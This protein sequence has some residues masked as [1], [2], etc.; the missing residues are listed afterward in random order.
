MSTYVLCT[1]HCIILKKKDKN[2]NIIKHIFYFYIQVMIKNHMNLFRCFLWLL[3]IIFMDNQE[4]VS[5][6][7]HLENNE[8]ITIV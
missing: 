3:G 1:I 7:F 4:T 8:E 2:S 6:D 5:R